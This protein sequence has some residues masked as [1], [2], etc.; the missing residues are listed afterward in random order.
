MGK[1]KVGDEVKVL[2]NEPNYSYFRK[3]DVFKIEKVSPERMNYGKTPGQRV[4]M[5]RDEHLE[6]KKEVNN[7]PPETTIRELIQ[8]YDRQKTETGRT[9]TIVVPSVTA[10]IDTVYAPKT[11][12]GDYG[13]WSLQTVL[14]TDGTDRLSANFRNCTELTPADKGKTVKLVASTSSR[15]MTGLRLEEREFTDNTGQHRAVLELVVTKSAGVQSVTPILHQVPGEASAP[16]PTPAPQAPANTSALLRSK[17]LE[18]CHMLLD[19]EIAGVLKSAKALGWNSEDIRALGIT[20]FL[21]NRRS[22]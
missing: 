5:V 9:P 7:M 3:G 1:F 18:A 15:G 14:L 19:E 12:V 6:L 2:R 8:E 20:L 10:K 11:G 16:A 21:E 4:N 22:R 13:P 17:L